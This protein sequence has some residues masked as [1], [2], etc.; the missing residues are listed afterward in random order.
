MHLL[1]NRRCGGWLEAFL[2]SQGIYKLSKFKNPNYAIAF[3]H[4]LKLTNNWGMN[5]LSIAIFWS[6]SKKVQKFFLNGTKLAFFV[7]INCKNR[8]AAE[9]FAP[10]CCLWCI[11]NGQQFFQSIGCWILFKLWHGQMLVFG[12]SPSFSKILDVVLCSITQVVFFCVCFKKFFHQLVL[13][14]NKL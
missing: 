7:S 4:V 10:G 9:C 5:W 12:W 2:F 13:Y 1:G 14:F 6:R 8:P 11:L 3:K